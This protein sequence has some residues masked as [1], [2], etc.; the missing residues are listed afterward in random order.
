MSTLNSK[1]ECYEVRES[2]GKGRGMFSASQINEGNKIIAEVPSVIGPKQ[3]SPFVCVDCFD[4]IDEQS[5][6]LCTFCPVFWV[7]F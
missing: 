1:N 5:G 2:V 3:T 6:K 7:E 4:Y